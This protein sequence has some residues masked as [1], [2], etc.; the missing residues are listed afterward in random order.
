MAPRTIAIDDAVRARLNPQLVILGA[1]LDGRAWRMGELAAV[2]VF[3][4]DHP[5]SQEDKRLRVGALQLKAKS[6]RFV[7]LDF[8][9][10]RSPKRWLRQVSTGR[11][12][13]RGSGRV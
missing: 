3:K 7:A 2:E 12:Q 8:S 13:R 9:A 5:A 11:L 1:G 4:V 6:I 10:T